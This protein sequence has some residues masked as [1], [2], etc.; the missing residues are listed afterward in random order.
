MSK[1]ENEFELFTLI[2]KTKKYINDLKEYC[3]ND[4]IIKT[5]KK[6]LI[7]RL[8]LRLSLLLSV[9][10]SDNSN[11]TDLNNKLKDLKTFFNSNFKTINELKNMIVESD[12]NEPILDKKIT[13]SVKEN[14]NFFNNNNS[15]LLKVD[16]LESE[17]KE[18]SDGEIT[19]ED[20]LKFTK[21]S[22][23][24]VEETVE[25][26]VEESVEESVEETVEEP[27]EESVNE[28]IEETVEESV[29]EPIEETVEE[30][31]VESVEESVEK[32]V[33]ESVEE[34][35]VESVEKPVEE[36]VEKSVEKSI[37]KSVEEENKSSNN[38]IL[39]KYENKKEF[40][41]E[42]LKISIHNINIALE[43]SDLNLEESHKVY[44]DWQLIKLIFN[45]IF[46]LN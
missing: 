44:E 28:P 32:P 39:P 40:T 11:V 19:N 38:F 2:K 4:L 37:E 8:N 21:N 12:L 30:S 16:T 1:E 7:K 14:N 5:Y 33:E 17:D 36:S 25:E 46:K 29:N 35:V 42:E 23:E 3:K 26:T 45:N 27:V 31:V 13:N 6:D 15:N 34:S 9:C 10:N 22:E 18:E 43:K 41:L 20:L 24:S